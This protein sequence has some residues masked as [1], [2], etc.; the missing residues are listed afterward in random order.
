MD[1]GEAFVTPPTCL[2]FYGS[3]R[4]H[5][6][7]NK[8]HGPIASVAKSQPK[9]WQEDDERRLKMG[10]LRRKKL[11]CWGVLTESLAETHARK[12]G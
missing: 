9:T 2:S 6:E 8:S 5:A 10:N 12:T 3:S 1:E 4:T 7:A 11:Y